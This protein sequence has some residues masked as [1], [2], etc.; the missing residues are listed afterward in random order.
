MEGKIKKIYM[1]KDESFRKTIKSF[2]EQI[3]DDEIKNI[4][5]IIEEIY[6]LFQKSKNLNIKSELDARIIGHGII[7]WNIDEATVGPKAFDLYRLKTMKYVIENMDILYDRICYPNSKIFNDKVYQKAI[8]IFDMKKRV[9]LAS[10]MDSNNKMIRMQIESDMSN[11]YRVMKENKLNELNDK[12]FIYDSKI[13]S[14]SNISNLILEYIRIPL[15]Q[16]SE[17]FRKKFQAGTL[18]QEEKKKFVDF[19]CQSLKM[20]YK[21]GY[22]K[23]IKENQIIQLANIVQA[24]ID[25]GTLK[26]NNNT[27]NNRLFNLK[28]K[29]LGFDYDRVNEDQKG[30]KS[31]C[32]K[33][34]AN[35]E[36]LKKKQYSI[37]E[38]S[39]MNAFYSNRLSKS[40]Y[41]FNSSIYVADKL[42]MFKCLAENKPFKID[43]SNN[44]IRKIL[45]QKIFLEE[46][47]RRI[48]IE[49]QMKHDRFTSDKIGEI[50][51]K[52]ENSDVL[53][54]SFATYEE[55]YNKYY[56]NNNILSKFGNDMKEDLETAFLGAV[57][58]KNLY[59][60]K[61]SAME[62]ALLIFLEEEKKKKGKKFNWGYIPEEGKINSIEGNKSRIL[63]GFDL[64]GFNTPVKLH[65]SK[66]IAE[67]VC[68]CIRKG[69]KRIIPVYSGDGD[70]TVIGIHLTTQVLAKMTK[71]QKGY[72]KDIL[73]KLPEDDF[74]KKFLEH[75]YF[76]TYPNRKN[77][78]R[79]FVDLE[80][81]KYFNEDEFFDSTQD[82]R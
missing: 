37:Q 5:K 70:T 26:N 47:A 9:E 33:D 46:I 3:S 73:K 61:D 24:L 2:E 6:E 39:V 19:F 25:N 14:N 8:D 28:M 60:M 7:G 78:K 65:A 23:E 15:A 51:K 49:K 22:E 52:E 48:I 32:I 36:F 10:K 31:F 41:N 81:G 72:L 82:N 29:F 67:R 17:E 75:L 13:H 79:K 12:D 77:E 63:F 30:K 76:M 42:N 54:K 40:I 16:Q 59:D 50:I 21:N 80:T 68:D 66:K 45:A 55:I 43:A 4:K 20:E 69:R 64:E 27:N 35:I 38:V 34:L 56:N 18:S 11:L 71:F 44:E 1:K 62:I 53:N 57:D 74:R 58:E